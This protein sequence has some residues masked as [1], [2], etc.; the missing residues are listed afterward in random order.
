RI[1]P[2]EDGTP[3]EFII[4]EAIRYKDTEGHKVQVFGHASYL[5][6]K[7]ASVLYPNS[8]NTWTASQHAG[9]SLNDTGWQIGII[10]SSAQRKMTINNHTNPY[11]FLKRIAN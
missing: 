11:E 1:I 7:K 3:I 6:L 4:F 8:G 9:W 10:E 5:E 2:D